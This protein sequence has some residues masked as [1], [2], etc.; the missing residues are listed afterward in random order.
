MQKADNL[1]LQYRSVAYFHQS[2]HQYRAQPIYEYELLQLCHYKVAELFDNPNNPNTD[3]AAEL[4]GQYGPLYFGISFLLEP[5]VE[6]VFL[7]TKKSPIAYIF[8]GL[9]RLENCFR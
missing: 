7:K 9:L 1:I 4:C 3:H 8:G 2:I 5:T 6:S